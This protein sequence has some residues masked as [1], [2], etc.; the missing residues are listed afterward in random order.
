MTVRKYLKPAPQSVF[1]R[2]WPVYP[3]NV[4]DFEALVVQYF[5]ELPQ[6]GEFPRISG[7]VVDAPFDQCDL[8]AL[9][10]NPYAAFSPAFRSEASAGF[11]RFP[12]ASHHCVLVVHP[13]DRRI[14]H[15]GVKLLSEMQVLSVHNFG[16]QAEGPCC[17]DHLRACINARHRTSHVSKLFG[18][19]AVSA[20]EVK[21][22]FFFFW[23]KQF[24]DRPA[25]Q[26]DKICP[27]FVNLR[28]PALI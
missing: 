12:Y 21:D 28:T 2:G 3:C 19:G 1:K 27:F 14:A 10:D 22:L 4:G 6:F 25:K 9:A 20:S 15:H 17:L 26:R 8:H 11:Q 13:V 5:R 7:L 16:F 23:I 24:D 18:Q